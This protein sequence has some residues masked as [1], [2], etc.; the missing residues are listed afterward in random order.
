MRLNK[1]DY[2]QLVVAADSLYDIVLEY[3]ENA[4]PSDRSTAEMCRALDKYDKLREI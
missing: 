4:L 2:A 3:C 1:E